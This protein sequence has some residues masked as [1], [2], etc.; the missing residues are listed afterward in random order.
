MNSY[1]YLDKK[2]IKNAFEFA[3]LNEKKFNLFVDYFTESKSRLRDLFANYKRKHICLL[4]VKFASD[5]MGMLTIYILFF[6]LL[7]LLI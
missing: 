2:L 7:F 1:E 6:Y 4:I 3:N 5:A